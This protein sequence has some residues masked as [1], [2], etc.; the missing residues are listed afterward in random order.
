VLPAYKGVVVRDAL[1]SYDQFGD[2]DQQLCGAHLL[3]D[4][5]AVTD[6][7]AAHP[8]HAGPLGWDWADQAAGA[9]LAVKRAR[10]RSPDRVCPPDELARQR[11]LLFS[12]AQI[13]AG[14]GPSPPG[15]LG[16]K[17]SALARRIVNRQDDYLRFA[18]DPRIPFDNNGSERDLR[19]AKLRMKVSGGLRTA[20]GADQFA[21]IRSYLSTAA[22]NGVDAFDALTRVFTWQP[23][24]PDTT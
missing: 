6:F 8:E 7:L 17:H 20:E 9:L 16:R 3:R 5:Q 12:A 4:L 22:K 10:D 24:L 19:M 21:R 18:E 13:A 1:A 14:A 15:P 11:H 2:A 23:Y